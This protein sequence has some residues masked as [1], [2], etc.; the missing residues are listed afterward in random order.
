MP[1]APSAPEVAELPGANLPADHGLTSLGLILQLGGTFF[2]AYSAI[3]A[4][5]GIVLVGTSEGRGSALWVFFI[6]GLGV[7][8]ALFHRAAGTQLLYGARDAVGDATHPFGGI[9]RYIVVGAAHAVVT[10]VLLWEKLAVERTVAGAIAIGLLVWPAALAVLV[11]LP[12]FRRCA[13]RLPVS[14]DKGFEGAAILMT[15][16]GLCGAFAT[17]TF[18]V[19]ILDHARSTSGSFL[20]HGPGFLVL[21]ALVML[22]VRLLV[23][24]ATLILINRTLTPTARASYRRPH[25]PASTAAP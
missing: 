7:T 18:L 8:R 11:S 20:L 22:G 19:G 17:G 21:L 14:E 2:A 13:D 1:P 4:F 6:L 10:G 25:E 3:L 23:P 9:R 16:L 12:R 5:L 24:I 15:M